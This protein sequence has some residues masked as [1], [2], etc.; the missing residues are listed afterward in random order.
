MFFISWGSRVGSPNIVSA[1]KS[2]MY[3]AEA[4]NPQHYKCNRA[5]S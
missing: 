1:S 5:C 2:V 4:S 3:P